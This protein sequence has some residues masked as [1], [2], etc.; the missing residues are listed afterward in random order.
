MSSLARSRLNSDNLRAALNWSLNNEP[1]TAL[2]LV[3][4]MSSHF[5]F[6]R[7]V[8]PGH[9]LHALLQQDP[10]TRHSFCRP[11][12]YPGDAG[13]M[14]IIYRITPVPQHTTALGN[15]VYQF[16]I[17]TPAVQSVRIRRLVLAAA[18][19]EVARKV[20]APR[21]LSVASGHGCEIEFSRAIQSGRIEVLTAFDQ[22]EVSIAEVE[23]SYGHLKIETVRGSVLDIA[24]G[25]V[26]LAPHDLIYSAET[27]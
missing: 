24:G 22:D 19:D 18:I 23:R 17:N 2:A 27:L 16:G 12:G 5:S 13:L 4:A 6:C 26:D 21:V 25:S 20:G 11:R 9:P 14:D 8:C 10:F 7:E 15:L 3:V 1:E